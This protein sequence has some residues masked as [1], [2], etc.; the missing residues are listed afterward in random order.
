MKQSMAYMLGRRLINDVIISSESNSL[1]CRSDRLRKADPIRARA[2]SSLDSTITKSNFYAS[3]KKKNDADISRLFSFRNGESLFDQ[4]ICRIQC[5]KTKMDF[6]SFEL[7]VCM[8]YRHTHIH[9]HSRCHWSSCWVSILFLGFPWLCCVCMVSS[10]Y[11]W[12]KFKQRPCVSVS[13]TESIDG[14]KRVR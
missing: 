13:E 9:T 1:C 5:V 8:Q 12:Q 4:L 14:W 10:V 11:A 3:R 2:T 7:F 6:F